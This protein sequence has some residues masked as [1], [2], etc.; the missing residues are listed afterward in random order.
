MFHFAGC[1]SPVLLLLRWASQLLVEG[2]GQEGEHCEGREALADYLNGGE[3]IM[4][5]SDQ[6]K[7]HRQTGPHLR[8]FVLKRMLSILVQSSFYKLS[9]GL[10][11]RS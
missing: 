6:E 5:L 9:L 3:E 2:V 1:Q 4:E 8:Q 7:T 10:R 11:L